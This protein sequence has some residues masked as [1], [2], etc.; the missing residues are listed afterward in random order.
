VTNTVVDRATSLV[1]A[2]TPHIWTSW[3][4]NNGNVHAPS[5]QPPAPAPTRAPEQRTCVRTDS[6]PH[7]TH[8]P[9]PQDPRPIPPLVPPHTL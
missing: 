6:L 3:P 8:N 4:F 9:R 1:S 7:S 5:R 2:A